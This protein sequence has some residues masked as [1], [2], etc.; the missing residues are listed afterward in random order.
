MLHDFH[1]EG[2]LGLAIKENKTRDV[3]RAGIFSIIQSIFLFLF[4]FFFPRGMAENL[5]TGHIPAQLSN[6]VRKLYTC[7]VSRNMAGFIF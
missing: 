4:L 1:F 7:F 5:D 2:L 6:K 3:S